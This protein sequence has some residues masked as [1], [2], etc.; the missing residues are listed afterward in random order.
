MQNHFPNHRYLSP[1]YSPEKLFAASHLTPASS[2]G[3]KF[4]QCFPAFPSHLIHKL[5]DEQLGLFQDSSF[6]QSQQFNNSEEAHE[7]KHDESREEVGGDL[8]QRRLLVR[9]NIDVAD[10]TNW[11]EWELIYREFYIYALNSID[12]NPRS[13]NSSSNPI[14]RYTLSLPH[15]S[16]LSLQNLAAS[17]IRPDPSPSLDKSKICG[18]EEKDKIE[19]TLP[20]IDYAALCPMTVPIN[21]GVLSMTYLDTAYEVTA[22]LLSFLNFLIFKP[23]VM[24]SYLIPLQRSQRL[25][26][27]L[28]ELTWTEIHNQ[29]SKTLLHSNTLFF[30]VFDLLCKLLE[31]P[32]QHVIGLA[33]IDLLV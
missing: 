4:F 33:N 13:M 5:Q 11:I 3:C 16:T 30:F 22:S 29:P 31:S 7:R 8:G 10:E 15:N 6:L 24:L 14:I 17:I 28:N 20:A 23:K 12:I 2:S 26:C 32:N 9:D 25:L 21:T 18:S 1:L 27:H 19:F